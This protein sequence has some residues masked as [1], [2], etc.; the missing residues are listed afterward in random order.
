MENNKKNQDKFYHANTDVISG[1]IFVTA[2]IIVM[3]L[4]SKFIS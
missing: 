2:A 1:I 3:Y 4:L